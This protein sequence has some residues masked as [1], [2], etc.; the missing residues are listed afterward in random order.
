MAGALV[1][2]VLRVVAGNVVGSAVG[3]GV[4]ARGAVV[5]TVPGARVVVVGALV[6]VPG[7]PVVPGGG[8]PTNI[9]HLQAWAT[10][11]VCPM[12]TTR[13]TTHAADSRYKTDPLSHFDRL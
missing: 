12:L 8:P 1:V 6:V 7:T 13:S 11:V 3:S 5:G 2:V 4:V 10:L 9:G